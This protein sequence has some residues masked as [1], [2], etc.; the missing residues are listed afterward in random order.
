M[1]LFQCEDS[2][3]NY[4]EGKISLW[5]NQS[6]TVRN[7]EG[8]VYLKDSKKR[9]EVIIDASN[10]N[11]GAWRAFLRPPGNGNPL[12]KSRVVRRGAPPFDDRAAEIIIEQENTI[13]HPPSITS[14]WT[15]KKAVGA[16]NVIVHATYEGKAVDLIDHA[17][18][19]IKSIRYMGEELWQVG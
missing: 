14:D 19:L 11:L 9:L 13:D 7:D 16:E 8:V 2:T 18:Q 12:I 15:L 4:D 1:S 3:M 17:E 6:M 5:K 10:K